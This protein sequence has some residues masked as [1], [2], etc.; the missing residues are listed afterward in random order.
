MLLNIDR[1]ELDALAESLDKL[2]GA[3]AIALGDAIV[4]ALQAGRRFLRL[5][6][7]EEAARDA[8][9]ALKR[10]APE[11]IA[12]ALPPVTVKAVK[13]PS[14]TGRFCSECGGHMVKTGTCDTCTSCSASGGCG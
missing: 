9:E 8:V 13:P 4:D 11:A 5:A 6:E 10:R 3:T 12:K 1:R 2:E 7:S 14:P